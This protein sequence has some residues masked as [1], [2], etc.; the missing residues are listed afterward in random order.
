M[1][2][3]G[4]GI[5]PGMGQPAKRLEITFPHYCTVEEYFALCEQT[6]EKIEYLG[7]F[8]VPCGGMAVAMAGAS[9]D[10]EMICTDIGGGLWQRLGD[11]DC[12][13]FG[14]NA[15][16]GVRGYPS[17]VHPDAML[18]CGP[19]QYDDCDT[20]EQTAA[21]T[22]LIVEFLSTSSEAYDRGNKFVRYMAA[23]SLQ[24]YVLVA[25]DEARVD[26]C[27]RQP[28]GTW[29]FTPHVG[30]DAVV[31]LRSIGVELPVAEVYLNVSLPPSP[32]GG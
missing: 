4:G 1:S 3:A 28:G 19:T 9:E 31:K 13:V 29:L 17:Y 21:N 8:A 7:N 25:Q 22:T 6:D 16:V 10:H 26:V 15:K 30:R 12:R 11:T 2:K 5:L 14:P 18:I 24:E 27:Y 20:S 23:E 32:E